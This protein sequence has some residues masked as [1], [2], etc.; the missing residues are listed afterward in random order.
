MV[1][2]VDLKQ[3]DQTLGTLIRNA[4]AKVILKN[5]LTFDQLSMHPK[6]VPVDEATKPLKIKVGNIRKGVDVAFYDDSDVERLALRKDDFG[7]L[8]VHDPER[9]AGLRTILT[10]RGSI[11][12]EP[13]TSGEHALEL[14]PFEKA[15]I[16]G[17]RVQN[18]YDRVAEWLADTS[19]RTARR[20][21]SITEQLYGTYKIPVLEINRGEGSQIATLGP[22]GSRRNR[23]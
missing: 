7:F 23:G 2:Q 16:F 4:D 5:K 21:H 20:D 9:L 12:N 22:H 17:G 1:T 13:R 18:L 14:G 10:G 8:D 19:L 15:R 6:V 11:G 3:G